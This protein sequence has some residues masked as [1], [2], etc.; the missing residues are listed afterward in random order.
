MSY[1]GIVIHHSACPSINGK[2]FDFYITKDCLI[3]PGKERTSPNFIHVCLEGDFSRAAPMDDRTR[4]QL[5]TACKL[6]ARL[7]AVH[8]IEPE[9][10]HAHTDG[11]PG[12]DFPWGELVIS[13]KNGYH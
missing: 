13:M 7:C 3:I 6:I 10:L 9:A 2:G 12:G 11:C 8:G 5:F 4:E 1:N